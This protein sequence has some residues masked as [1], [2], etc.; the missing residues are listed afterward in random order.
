MKKILVILICLPLFTFSQNITD[1]LLLYYN[2]NGNSQDLSGNNFHGTASGVTPVQDRHGNDSSSYYFDGV[3]DYIDFPLNDTLK[4]N[5]PV[6]LAVW[7]KLNTLQIHRNKIISTDF[8]QDDYHGIRMAISSDGRVHVSIGGGIGGCNS[9]NS[10]GHK[11]IEELSLDT[12]IWYQITT[13]IRSS[14]D[15]EIWINCS[16]G[17]ATYDNGSGPSTMGVSSFASG[18]VGRLDNN[19]TL[20]PYYNWGYIDELYYW[21]RALTS[22]E[23]YTLC[24]SMPLIIDTTGNNTGT[25]TFINEIHS[26]KKLLKIVDV[27]GRETPYRKNTPLFYIYEEGTVEKKIIIE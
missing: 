10:I 1:S 17:Y 12:G 8:V 24:D 26:N 3:N 20:P 15:V 27:L 9:A 22:A 25:S 5:F 21:N 14:T 7:I 23:I 11:T 16:N 6:T 19:T 18:T 4:P 2:M 13:V